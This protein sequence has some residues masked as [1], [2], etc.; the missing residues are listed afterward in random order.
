[1]VDKDDRVIFRVGPEGAQLFSAT[2]EPVFEL[3]ASDAG[4]WVRLRSGDA[5][6][7]FAAT[8]RSSGLQ[9]REGGVTR[10]DMSSKAGGPYGFRV[11]SATSIIAGIGQ[12]RAGS[13]V[14]V[15]GT[16]TEVKATLTVGGG[17]GMISAYTNSSKDG[18]ALTEA[19]IGG[20]LIDVGMS[21][22]HSAVKMGHNGNRY[23][24]VMAGPTLG[25]PLVPRTGLPGSYFM[26]CASGDRPAC[27][28]SIAAGN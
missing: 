18:V 5:D 22:G 28:P 21:N 13:G 10:M 6:V 8:G 17:R 23:G 14:V 7:S 19:G 1:V 11:S 9:V 3:G 20:G 16:P 24:I 26:G 27:T 12:S 25:L 4:G 15:I 2:S